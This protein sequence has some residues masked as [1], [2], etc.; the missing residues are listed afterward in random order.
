MK[1][2]CIQN[3]VVIDTLLMPSLVYVIHNT[4]SVGHGVPIYNFNS[5]SFVIL[6]PC[7][8]VSLINTLNYF[9]VII[10]THQTAGYVSFSFYRCHKRN[11]QIFMVIIK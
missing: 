3:S 1:H 7:V 5:V 9:T 4:D 2:N 8:L 10:K 11:K 6:I